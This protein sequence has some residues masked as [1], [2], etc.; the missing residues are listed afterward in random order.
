MEMECLLIDMT[1]FKIINTFKKARAGILSTKFGEIKTPVFMPVGTLGSVKGISID[2]LHKHNFDII[3]ANTYHLMLRP[4]M[5]VIQKFKGLNKFM[6][7]NKSI[8]TDSGGFQIMSLGKNVKIDNEG[9]TFQSHLD[10]SKVR[11][12]A[13]KSIKIQRILNATITMSFDECIPHP[14][15]YLDT[16]YSLE[17]S[18]IWTKRSLKAYKQ[19]NGYGIF[20]IVQGG[21]Y[22]DLREKSAEELSKLDFDGYSIGGLAVGEGHKLMSEITKFSC[23]K[24]PFEKPRYLMGVGYPN[25]ILQAVKNGVDMFDCVL[26]TRSGRTGLAFTSK[27]FIKI[28][29]SA[30]RKDSRPLDENCDCKI[31]KNYSRAYLHHLV[32]SSE[33]LGSVFL[34]QH[35]LYFYNKFLQNIRNAISNESLDNLN[36]S[37]K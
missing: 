25:D 19:K 9:V 33:I 37:L 28:R 14:F 32:K 11:L 12:N 27:G 16:A 17:R 26:P 34:T 2:F 15:S 8:L 35:N 21:M 3:L 7:W 4:G 31:C 6:S 5:D 18:T 22:K 29:N 10:G 1:K 23:S 30:Y 36:F 13:E 20:G 24:L